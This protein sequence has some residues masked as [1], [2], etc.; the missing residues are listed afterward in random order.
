MDGGRVLRALIALRTDYVRATRLAARIGQLFAIVFVL[1][2][3][4]SNPILIFFAIFVWLGAAGDATQVAM[5]SAL[6]G[7][8]AAALG[9]VTRTRSRRRS[10]R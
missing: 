2:G 3:L 1:V 10:A 6:Q 7:P 5:Q 8:V 4:R 9:R